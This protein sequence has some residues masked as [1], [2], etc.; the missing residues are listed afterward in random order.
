MKRFPFRD[1]YKYAK[2]YKSVFI[3]V[4]FVTGKYWKQPYPSLG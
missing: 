2:I 4:L 3:E 1:M